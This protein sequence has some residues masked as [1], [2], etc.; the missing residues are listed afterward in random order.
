MRNFP[1]SLSA[2]G[3]SIIN[4]PACFEK[5]VSYVRVLTVP[6]G[7][8]Y[9]KDTK[10][11]TK[12]TLNLGHEIFRPKNIPLGIFSSVLIIKVRV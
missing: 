8:K 9:L 12:S 10:K 11:E 5:R 6:I 3:V 4:W 7:Q 2:F 1:A